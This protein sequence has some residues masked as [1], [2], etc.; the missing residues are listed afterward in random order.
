M[1]GR[2][3]KANCF[4]PLTGTEVDA[5]RLPASGGVGGVAPEVASAIGVTTVVPGSS[6]GT[7]RKGRVDG[8]NGVSL[9]ILGRPVLAFPATGRH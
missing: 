4:C 3:I 9:G 8:A 6:N 7:V 2:L 1:K 5:T